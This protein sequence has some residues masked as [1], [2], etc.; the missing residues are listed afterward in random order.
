MSAYSNLFSPLPFKVQFILQVMIELLTPFLIC[1]LITI[2]FFSDEP[3]IRISLASHRSQD[4]DAASWFHI[5]NS[6]WLAITLYYQTIH[7]R[8]FVLYMSCS[9]DKLNQISSMPA[10]QCIINLQQA[11]VKI[12]KVKQKP[13]L[14]IRNKAAFGSRPWSQPGEA[15]YI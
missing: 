15:L 3:L 10:R 11:W 6:G 12:T 2:Y 14:L 8:T 7:K 4:S 5:C 13:E 1:I 9:S